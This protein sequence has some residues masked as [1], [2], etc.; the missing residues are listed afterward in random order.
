MNL[1]VQECVDNVVR[2]NDNIKIPT[3]S[4][5]INTF[6]D[7]VS[8]LSDSVVEINKSI[9]NL[10]ESLEKLTWVGEIKENDF[11]IINI[12]IKLSSASLKTLKMNYYMLQETF[13]DKIPNVIQEN[14]GVVEDLEETINDVSYSFFKHKDTDEMKNLY[15]ELNDLV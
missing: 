3:S 11:L 14:L 13:G 8:F 7:K 12:V 15:K 9:Q 10:T 6:L 5:E 1:T 4:E 2:A